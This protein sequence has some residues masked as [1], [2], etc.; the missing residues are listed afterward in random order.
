MHR[1][2]TRKL[3]KHVGM[4]VSSRLHGIYTKKDL[5]N[6]SLPIENLY[7]SRTILTSGKIM[8]QSH[9]SEKPF[10][11]CLLVFDREKRN[12]DLHSWSDANI[13][14]CSYDSQFSTVIPLWWNNYSFNSLFLTFDRPG[15]THILKNFIFFN[16]K[17]RKF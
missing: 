1:K 15:Y 16:K 2:K 11:A 7:I 10:L 14:S 3:N 6:P 17:S 13:F 9:E 12:Y 4:N 5:K 8:I